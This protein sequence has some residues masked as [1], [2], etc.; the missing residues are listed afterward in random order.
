LEYFGNWVRYYNCRR[1]LIILKGKEIKGIVFIAIPFFIYNKKQIL[2]K[3]FNIKELLMTIFNTTDLSKSIN[4]FNRKGTIATDVVFTNEATNVSTN[5]NVDSLSNT[6]YYDV[7]NFTATDGYFNEN[8][9]YLFEIKDASGDI[10]FKDKLFVTNQD[11]SNN[12]IYDINKNRY[13]PNTTTNEYT[14]YE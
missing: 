6:S 8:D 12:L 4:Y 3:S 1:S 13:K 14:I 2:K 11:I 9:F 10:I 7:L 5:F